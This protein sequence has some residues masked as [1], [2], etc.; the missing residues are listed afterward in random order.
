MKRNALALGVAAALGM[1]GVAQA[2]NIVAA[3]PAAPIATAFDFNPQG[4]GHVLIL[5]YYTAAGGNFTNINLVNT[6]PANGKLLKVRFRSAANSDDVFDFQLFMSPNDMWTAAIAEDPATG[7]AT[8]LTKDTS[9]TLPAGVK[10]GTANKFVTD[11]INA[12]GLADGDL[13]AWTREGY[14]EVLNMAD[15]PSTT[16]PAAVVAATYTVDVDANAKPGQLFRTVKHVSGVAPCDY[17]GVLNIS[18]YGKEFADI[19][20]AGKKGLFFPSGKLFG[21][22]TIVNGSQTQVFSSEFAAIVATSNTANN[23]SDYGNF[24][25]FPQLDGAPT[26]VV[27]NLTSDPLLR[28]ANVQSA[29]GAFPAGVALPLVQA[30][31]F[32]FPDL[33]TPYVGAVGAATAPITSAA[34][35]MKAVATT[36]VS[37][38]FFNNVPEYGGKTDWVFSMPLR[39]YQVA[40]DYKRGDKTALVPGYDGRV[41]TISGTPTE[42]Y[43]SAANTSLDAAGGS[44]ICVKTDSVTQYD[45]EEGVVTGGFVISPGTATSI[46]FCGEVSVVS[47]GGTALPQTPVLGSRVAGVSVSS[48]YKEGW[49]QIGTSGLNGNGLPILGK[50]YMSARNGA[51]AQGVAANYGM[52]FAHRYAKP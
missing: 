26:S 38:E 33:S 22:A 52:S 40:M 14:V 17:A 4:V 34:K 1:V 35:L 49:M 28:T 16:A 20:A 15:I 24:S 12:V 44:K 27:D 39:R 42:Q 18:N 5:P 47:V 50:A 45:R 23:T 25:F 48:N 10:S 29:G 32:D 41:F 8:L 7:L 3:G 19:T 11:R 51:A 9:C 2:Q 6:D 21:N 43:F 36:S 37:N 13:Q 31:S 46:R 30:A